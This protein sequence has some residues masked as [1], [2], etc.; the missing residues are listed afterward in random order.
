CT[1]LELGLNLL[2]NRMAV[3]Q[4]V[5]CSSACSGH[6]HRASRHSNIANHSYQLMALICTV[7]MEV[8]CSWRS[9]KMET[10]TYCLL[11]SHCGGRNEGGMVVFLISSAAASHVST[12]NT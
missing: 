10:L 1:Y 8:H 9:P 4:P 2:L 3:I 11:P 5:S 7:N 6:S 12:G